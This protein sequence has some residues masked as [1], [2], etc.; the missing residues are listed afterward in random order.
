M[1]N[2]SSD[3]DQNGPN[4]MHSVLIRN[5][6]DNKSFY[7]GL[8]PVYA[9]KYHPN[10]FDLVFNKDSV[11]FTSSKIK[12]HIKYTFMKPIIEIEDFYKTN[13]RAKKYYNGQRLT[14]IEYYCKGQCTIQ[15]SRY[16]Q[17][18]TSNIILN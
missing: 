16:K 5:L 12:V 11:V 13:T 3:Y 14:Y 18:F 8:L 4:H 6:K 2:N 9:K 10:N 1:L 7:H 17:E 15:S